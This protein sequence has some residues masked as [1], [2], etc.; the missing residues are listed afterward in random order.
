[1]PPT[2]C[3]RPDV[4]HRHIFG[5]TSAPESTEGDA[6]GP[7]INSDLACLKAQH[8]AKCVHVNEALW[9][10]QMLLL[11]S[12]FLMYCTI[13]TT[14]LLV[15]VIYSLYNFLSSSISSL[16]I[17]YIALWDISCV[18]WGWSILTLK[19]KG[20]VNWWFWEAMAYIENV[21]TGHRYA[22][23]LIYILKIMR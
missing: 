10:V 12:S 22:W 9:L 6:A 14:S 1:M 7:S 16:A 19:N 15:I 3:I 2:E 8:A 23:I 5:S 20:D 21:L 4:T 13:H 11:W 18:I 17:C